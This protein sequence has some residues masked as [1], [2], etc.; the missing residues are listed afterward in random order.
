ME[1]RFEFDPEAALD[2]ARFGVWVGFSGLLAWFYIWA[3]SL[4][5]GMYLGSHDLGLYQTGNQSVV[6]VYGLVFAPLLPVLYSHFSSIQHDKQRLSNA[7]SRVMHLSALIAIPMAFL[8]FTISEPL[9]DALFGEKW[10]GI[11]FVVGVMALA[12]GY[13]WLVGVSGEIYRAV[14]KPKY[15]PFVMLLGFAVYL[16]GYLIAIQYGFSEF[17]WTR[18]LL[19]VLGYWLCTFI[20]SRR[21]TM[22][23]VWESAGFAAKV[24]IRE[25]SVTAA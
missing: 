24:T 20:F 11:G 6:L 3:D 12:H 8:L 9:A 19:V 15:D 21:S 23:S 18:F 4:V 10:K 1:T 7:L 22:T 16:P 2:L 5:V 17:V 25:C 14:G 13:A